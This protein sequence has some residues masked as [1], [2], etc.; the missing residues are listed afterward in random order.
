LLFFFVAFL[1][2]FSLRFSF[3]SFVVNFSNSKSKKDYGGLSLRLRPFCMK[4]NKSPQVSK[5][6]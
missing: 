3:V 5:T 1:Y 2:G 4:R 6:T